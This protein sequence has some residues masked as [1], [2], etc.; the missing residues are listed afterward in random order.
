MATRK[1]RK[2]NREK[3]PCISGVL[4]QLDAPSLP[5]EDGG[6]VSLGGKK[7]RTRLGEGGGLDLTLLITKSNK[8]KQTQ[9]RRLGVQNE[10]MHREAEAD[11]LHAQIQALHESLAQ[12]SF[13]T[14]E[15]LE[16]TT[17]LSSCF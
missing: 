13:K 4:F 3:P 1:R 9:E 16:C 11:A 8:I 17:I 12:V 14:K 6:T 15:L 5:V 7:W 10:I 2:P